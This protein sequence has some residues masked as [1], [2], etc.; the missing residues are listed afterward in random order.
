MYTLSTSRMVGNYFKALGNVERFSFVYLHC[1]GTCS[2]TGKFL[3][4]KNNCTTKHPAWRQKE[5][6]KFPQ[7]TRNRESAD[8]VLRDRP[9]QSKPER[10]L[11]GKRL[12]ERFV[13]KT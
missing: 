2:E 7:G 12:G 4:C 3:D 6:Q 10:D 8:T 5:Y 9:T 1:G 11:R 13:T